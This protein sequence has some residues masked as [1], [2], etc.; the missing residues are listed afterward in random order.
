[1]ISSV[2]FVFYVRSLNLHVGLVV[3]LCLSLIIFVARADI[4]IDI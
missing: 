1:M 3:V 4:S 2:N